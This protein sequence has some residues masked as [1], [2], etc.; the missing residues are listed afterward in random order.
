LEGQ[1]KPNDD[2]IKLGLIKRYLR[3]FGAAGA[4][5]E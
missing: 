4:E 3:M 1:P 2:R 5:P